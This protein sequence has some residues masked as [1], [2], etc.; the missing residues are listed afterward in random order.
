MCPMHL[1]CCVSYALELLC[2]LCT[3]VVACPTHLGCC[4][5]YAP[6]LLR[7]LCTWVVVCPMHLG[8]CVSYA[9]GLLLCVLITCSVDLA[10]NTLNLQKNPLFLLPRS[11]DLV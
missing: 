8:C 7:V 2:V 3:W 4:V 11:Y 6:G 5:S 1:S 10:I 9:P